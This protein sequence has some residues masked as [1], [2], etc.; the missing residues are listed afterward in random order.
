M[1][2]RKQG[3]ER[4]CWEQAQS[5]YV[6]PAGSQCGRPRSS[7][8][9]ATEEAGLFLRLRDLDSMTAPLWRVA[10]L[11]TRQ[12]FIVGLISFQK[13]QRKV[14]TT[15]NTSWHHRGF[16]TNF[17]SIFDLMSLASVRNAC[18]QGQI[19]VIQM[20]CG[21]F[22]TDSWNKMEMYIFH[23]DVGFRAGLHE[24]NPVL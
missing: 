21:L 16:N 23:I 7:E 10:L 9:G 20:K 4:K 6:Q 22:G 24:L 17:V 1:A 5:I 3:R 13:P 19:R 18:K 12:T 8:E 11:K 14:F 2:E 15:L